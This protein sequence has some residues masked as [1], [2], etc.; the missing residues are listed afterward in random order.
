M[1]KMQ[2]KV[3]FSASDAQGNER[4]GFIDANTNSEAIQKLEEN[5][6]SDITLHY[7][8]IS[9][10]NRDDLEGLSERELQRIANIEIQSLQGVGS[11]TLFLQALRQ[12]WFVICIGLAGCAWGIYS[13]STVFFVLG[14]ITA[15]IAPVIS[16]KNLITLSQY[17]RLHEATALGE[18]DKAL[19]L[20]HTLR[21]KF[22]APEMAFDLDIKEACIMAKQGNVSGAFDFLAPWQQK[23]DFSSPG[24]YESRAAAIY[25]ISGDFDDLLEMMR[26]AY[27]KSDNNQMI[28]LD[29][30]SMEARY[31]D[32]D[33]AQSLMSNIEMHA[34][35]PMCL[36]FLDWVRGLIAS[37]TNDPSAS[38]SLAA[39]VSKM[40]EYGNDSITLVLLA[41]MTGSYAR[42]LQRNGDNEGAQKVL[43]NIWPVLKENGDEQLVQELA[44]LMEK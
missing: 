38:N 27:D 41:L 2:K 25:Y 6:F 3:L 33:N 35:A 21:P 28:L 9:C 34:L 23:F 30:I 39:A 31:G 22:K 8:A 32:I 24:M 11:G 42:E 14:G 37:R 29:L 43:H 10:G 16:L 7:D 5:G 18:H 40:L 19:K 1:E 15:L 13:S 12:N 44:P 4:N 26:E 17:T 36:P 20:I